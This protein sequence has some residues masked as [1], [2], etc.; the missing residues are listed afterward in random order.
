MKVPQ[1]P[2]ICMCM[3]FVLLVEDAILPDAPRL[4]VQSIIT[5]MMQTPHDDIA[6]LRAEI[7]AAAARMIAQDGADYGTAKRKA[8]RQILGESQANAKRDLLPDDAQVEEEVRQYHALFH[9]DTQPARL[10]RLRTIALEVMEKLADYEPYVTGA[11]LNGTAG[12]H[13]DIRLQLF[14]DSAKEVQI[15][16]LNHNVN[17]EISESEHFKGPRHDPVET[18]SFLWHGEGVHVECYEH[19]DLRGAKKHKSGERPARA[20]IADLRALLAEEHGAT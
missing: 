16:L 20:G 17:I 10:F 1:M 4:P 12:E 7:A 11:V 9:A 2:S 6:L 14:A 8:A 13:D 19:N 5:P 3:V 18:V 15:Y